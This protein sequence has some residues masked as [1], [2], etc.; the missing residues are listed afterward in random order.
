MQLK[1]TVY[2]WVT[3]LS[4]VHTMYMAFIIFILIR[5]G[6]TKVIH[7]LTNLNWKPVFTD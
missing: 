4:I 3:F 7:V 1:R 6:L 2:D 5:K